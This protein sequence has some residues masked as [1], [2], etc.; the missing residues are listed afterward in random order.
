MS[1]G[2]ELNTRGGGPGVVDFLQ[3]NTGGEVP[4]NASN[5]VFIVGAGDISVT[6][7]P[8]T[9]T[10]TIS[11]TG[12]PAWNKIAASQPLVSNNGYI[13]TGG[14]VLVLTLPATSL[15][16]DIIEITLDGSTGFM[17]AQGAGQ[18][19]LI[20]NKNTTTGVGGSLTSTQQG[21]SL[22]MVCSVTNLR[23]NVLS[24]MGNPIVV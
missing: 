22:R 9:N 1:Q 2:G 21:D 8:A 5:V 16:G 11:A 18:S 10:L 17:V 12:L 15:V 14:G 4:P 23:W 3:G 19:I 6:G 7:N 20:G 13:C 24:S